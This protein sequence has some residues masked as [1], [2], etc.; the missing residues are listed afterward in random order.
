MRRVTRAGA[1]VQEEGLVGLGRFEVGD[2][3][4]R[5]VGEV[6]GEVIPPVDRTRREDAVVVVHERRREL[7]RL[8]TEVAVEALEPAAEGPACPRRP[9]M[10][11]LERSE[12]PFADG[13]RGVAL[14]HEHLGQE[15]VL[16]ADAAV[17]PR[18]AGD[19]VGDASH[20][21]AVVVASR[22]HTRPR[23]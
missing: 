6:L 21:D 16:L 22:K 10:H 15:A 7:V 18:E 3:L 4:H 9:E 5:A 19:E 14:R 17:V 12:V 1:E 20:A 11:L 2:E 23:R 13:V 8:T